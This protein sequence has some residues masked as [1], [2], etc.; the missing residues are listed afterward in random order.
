VGVPFEKKTR[1]AIDRL[2]RWAIEHGLEALFSTAEGDRADV[3]D[4]RWFSFFYHYRFASIPEEIGLLT[5]LDISGTPHHFAATVAKPDAGSEEE[6]TDGAIAQ[7][8]R[9]MI[10]DEGWPLGWAIW[11]EDARGEHIAYYLTSRF[12]DTHGKIYRD[13]EHDASLPALW[14]VG[15]IDDRY[16]ALEADLQNRGLL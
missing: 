14:Q 11:D 5:R 16:Y 3:L 10:G 6:L 1:E 2:H 8:Q 15:P 7:K 9:F 4:G 12:G 13:G